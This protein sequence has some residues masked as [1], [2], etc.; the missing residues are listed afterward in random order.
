MRDFATAIV[1]LT[2]CYAG[3]MHLNFAWTVMQMQILI[4][5]RSPGQLIRTV[6]F[7][8]PLA[9][10]ISGLWS[11]SLVSQVD[12]SV[13]LL[14]G[15]WCSVFDVY[16]VPYTCSFPRFWYRVTGATSFLP[17]VAFWTQCTVQVQGT[18]NS[19]PGTLYAVRRALYTVHYSLLAMNC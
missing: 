5:S 1:T 6:S 17:P 7:A 2:L 10:V 15:V 4:Q 13:I 11:R 19:V 8:L 9:G 12:Y 16:S 3:Q 14:F 18:G